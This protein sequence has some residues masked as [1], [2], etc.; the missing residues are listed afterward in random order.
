MRKFI[1]SVLVLIAAASV[2]SI[3]TANAQDTKKKHPVVVNLSGDTTR[4]VIRTDSIRVKSQ[5]LG[6]RI[7][8]STEVAADSIGAFGERMGEKMQPVAD[9]IVQ[10]S[11]RAWRALTGKDQKPETKKEAKK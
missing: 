3:Y 1:M 10:R 6:H 7:A 8:E 9:T 2:S 11:R 4:A 5:R